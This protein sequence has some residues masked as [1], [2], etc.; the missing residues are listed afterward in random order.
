VRWRCELHVRQ[1]C[2]AGIEQATPAPGVI[3]AIMSASTILIAPS[4]PPASILPTV[5]IPGVR[6]A[7]R[8]RRERVWAISPVIEALALPAGELVRARS[9][10]RLL[11][12]LGLPH[13]PASVGQLYQDFCRHFVLDER[14]FKY[15][16]HLE[17]M[18]YMVYLLRTDALSLERQKE[19]A[20]ELLQLMREEQ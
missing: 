11:A 12:S 20:G 10:D 15:R 13:N 18:G 4:N 16:S 3:E 8:A 6:E 9:R 19:L 1:V 17:A 7:L 14:D 2:Y 5:T